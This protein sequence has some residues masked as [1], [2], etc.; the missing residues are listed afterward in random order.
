MLRSPSNGTGLQR[1][2][3]PV[4]TPE[5]LADL[6]A[7]KEGFLCGGLLMP[8]G[9]RESA[10]G[11]DVFP[12]FVATDDWEEDDD[13]VDDDDDEDEEEEDEDEDDFFPGDGDEFEE[14]DEDED[15]DE[16]DE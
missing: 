10:V 13:V 11:D 7:R 4:G 5:E 9:W 8:L 14:E 15:E 12:R 3:L 16:E 6:R 1:D 2:A